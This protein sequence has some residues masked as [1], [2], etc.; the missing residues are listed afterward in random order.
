M[1]DIRNDQTA[2]VRDLG[3]RLGSWLVLGLVIG[4][5]YGQVRTLNGKLITPHRLDQFLTQQLDSLGL[6][7]LSIAII[8]EARTPNCWPKAKSS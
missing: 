6:P 7:S 2:I 3:R 5:T 1:T 4:T 8:N